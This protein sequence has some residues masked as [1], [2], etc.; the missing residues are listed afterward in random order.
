M[1]RPPPF[2]TKSGTVLDRVEMPPCAAFLGYEFVSIDRDRGRMRVRFKGAKEMLNP[3]GGVQ[4]GMLVAMLDDAMGSM[5]VALTDGAKAP[6]SVDIHTQ[7]L[8]PAG[9]EPLM[10]E[11]ELVYLTKNSAF[12]RATLFNEAGDIV[13]TATQT[14]KL[15]DLPGTDH[16]R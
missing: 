7:F 8:R 9:L 16:A 1:N 13:A 10:C 2:T 15:F 14:A 4:G 6:A 11:A 5:V 12:I 3:R